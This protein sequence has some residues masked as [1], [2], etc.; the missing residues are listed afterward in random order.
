VNVS[1]R[2]IMD[3]DREKENGGSAREHTET[4]KALVLSAG[5]ALFGVAPLPLDGEGFGGYPRAVSVGA[6]L[7]RG[8]LDT[9]DD[10]PTRIYA[11]HYRTINTFLDQTA[12][13]VVSYIEQAGFK[14]LHVPASQIV[15][16]ENLAGRISHKEIG[17]LAG[18]G[19]IGRNN[20]LVTPR[21]GVA[22]RLV[23]ILT[24]TPLVENS[25]V[26]GDCAGCRECVA[27]CP[28]GA[29]GETV[30]DFDLEKCKEK[31]R[32]FKKHLVGHHICGVCVKVCKGPR[33]V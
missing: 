25:P 14:S 19:F 9:I 18:L 10:T 11:Y 30:E 27:V 6:V 12:A 29:I 5:A 21:F 17:R 13:R 4:L 15:D 2:R 26:D 1:R 23:S 7:S 3:G 8:V 16:W 22:V 28:A 32:W 24:D 33:I 31:L 20:L